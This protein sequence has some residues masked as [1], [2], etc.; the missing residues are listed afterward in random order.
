MWPIKQEIL[1]CSPSPLAGEGWGEGS[2]TGI[3]IA[4]NCRDKPG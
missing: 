3:E 2:I 4:L 1:S